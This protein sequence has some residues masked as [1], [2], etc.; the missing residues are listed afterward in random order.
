MRKLHRKNIECLTEEIY[1]FL[2]GLS[3]P[4]MKDIFEEVTSITVETSS[5]FT[6]LAKQLWDLEL[7][8]L[9]RGVKSG[10]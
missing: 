1:K 5:Y 10:T 6:L 2:R 4:I 8:R 7:T 3:L 9:L